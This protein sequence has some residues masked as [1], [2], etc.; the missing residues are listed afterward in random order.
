MK[1]FKFF[2]IA[3]LCLAIMLPGCSSSS[4]NNTAKGG[5]IGGTS[6]A[7]VGALIGGLIGKGKGAGIGAAVGAAVGTGAGVLIGKKMDKAAEQAKQ[8]E[9]AKVE[10]GETDGVQYVKV[11]LDSGITFKT[12]EINL[13]TTA[14]NSLATFASQLDPQFDLAICGHTDNVGTLEVNKRISKQRAQSVANFL[15]S[16]GVA[17]SR[18]KSVEGYDYQYPVASND[19]KEGQAQNRRVELYLI[20]SEAMIAEANSQAK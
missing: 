4:L 6:G 3:F 14:Q 18:L 7:G 5:I 13:S 11:T 2:A 8:I 17:A 1:R 19:T 15:E 16:K 20:P 10:K 12:N 9:G